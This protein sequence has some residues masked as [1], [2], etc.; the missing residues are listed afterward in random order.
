MRGEWAGEGGRVE[1]RE[2]DVERG[3]QAEAQRLLRNRHLRRGRGRVGLA[4]GSGSGVGYGVSAVRVR[5]RGLGDRGVGVGA[6]LQQ[7]GLITR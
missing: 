5:P 1:R 6:G 2:A 3:E 7:I 4:L